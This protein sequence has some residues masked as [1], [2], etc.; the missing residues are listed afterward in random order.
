MTLQNCCRVFNSA[1]SLS[2]DYKIR[3]L[4]LESQ[5]EGMENVPLWIVWFEKK[6]KKEKVSFPTGLSLERLTAA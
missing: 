5:D 3:L 6:N 1:P 4:Y 2:N